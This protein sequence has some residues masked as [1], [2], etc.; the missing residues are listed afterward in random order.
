MY[1]IFGKDGLLYLLLLGVCGTSEAVDLP[2]YVVSITVICVLAAVTNIFDVKQT[3][4][5]S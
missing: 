3:R 1:F 4:G 5:T 2:M